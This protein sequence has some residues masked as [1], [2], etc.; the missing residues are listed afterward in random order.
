MTTAD[1]ARWVEAF[2]RELARLRPQLSRRVLE[3]VSAA[4][5]RERGH[6]DVDPLVAAHD[7]ATA[8]GET[9]HPDRAR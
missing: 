1:R 6:H 5:W 3:A 2:E 9:P 4:A 7:S 8:I